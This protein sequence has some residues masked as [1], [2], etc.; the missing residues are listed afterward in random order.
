MRRQCWLFLWKPFT[1]RA[2]GPRGAN[3]RS[4]PKLRNGRQQ[5]PDD[6]DRPIAT[7]AHHGRAGDSDLTETLDEMRSGIVVAGLRPRRHDSG[8]D[9]GATLVR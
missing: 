3:R 4:A 6:H 7:S 1:M 5:S 8:R 2:V 9:Q